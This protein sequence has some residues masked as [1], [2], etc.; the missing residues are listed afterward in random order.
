[1]AFKPAFQISNFMNHDE[2]PIPSPESR[3]EARPVP[4]YRAYEISE[5]RIKK[6][7]HQQ[8]TKPKSQWHDEIKR[9][10]VL[11]NENIFEPNCSVSDIKGMNKT[12]QKNYSSRFRRCVGL[13]PR[14]YIST[15]RITA[16]IWL[17]RDSQLD[18]LKIGDI[19]FCVGFERPHSF[20]MTFKN[21]IGQWPGEWRK[22]HRSNN[23]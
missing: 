17:L 1:M 8:L 18:E 9:G 3:K 19:G 5:A 10:I 2:H 4:I 21:R 12:P 14:E 15:H 20:S 13:T 7:K 6:Y 16:A 11:I 22:S 23:N